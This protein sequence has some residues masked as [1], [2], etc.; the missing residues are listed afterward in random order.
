[1]YFLS[2]IRYFK[3]LITTHKNCIPGN[4]SCSHCNFHQQNDPI[5]TSCWPLVVTS[6]LCYKHLVACY[7]TRLCWEL[8]GLCGC[9]CLLDTPFEPTF[10][11]FMTQFWRHYQRSAT[12]RNWI[13]LLMKVTVRETENSRYAIFMFC[14]QHMKSIRLDLLPTQMN[15]HLYFLSH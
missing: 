6:E 1:M 13:I 15:F 10:H 14:D 11:I 7:C 3:L 8:V 9:R 5:P 2:P 12:C 4:F